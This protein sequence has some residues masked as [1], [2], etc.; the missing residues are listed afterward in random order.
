MTA[1]PEPGF[2]ERARREPIFN[3]PPA[4]LALCG[5]LCIAHVVVHI[6]GGGVADYAW[7]ILYGAHPWTPALAGHGFVH[8][9]FGHLLANVGMLLAFGTPVERRYGG[10]AL[11]FL[12]VASLIGGGL[13]FALATALLGGGAGLIGASG[14]VLGVTGAAAIVMLRS[15]DLRARRAG[16]AI[17]AFAIIVNAAL[18]LLGDA[19]ALF[20]VRI[21]WQAHLGG[22]AAGALIAALLPPRPGGALAKGRR[23]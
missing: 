19:V 3:A 4:T 20:G 15:D 17:L 9:G 1:H 13:A 18:A 8:A 11:L 2:R 14:A 12:F 5:V 10:P 22:L 21:G 6:F 7:A 23:Y 16:A